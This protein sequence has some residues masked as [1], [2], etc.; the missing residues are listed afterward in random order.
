MIEN[1]NLLEERVNGLIAEVG[2]LRKE[3]E[4]GAKEE[5][6]VKKLLAER[7]LLK[8]KVEQLIAKIEEIE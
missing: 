1:L 8:K 6:E 5:I 4:H 7:E 2:R 3:R